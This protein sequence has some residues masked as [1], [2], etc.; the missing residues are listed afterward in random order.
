MKP[1][2]LLVAACAIAA[3][4]TDPTPGYSPYCIYPGD[5]LGVLKRSD[6]AKTVVIECIW[7]LADSEQCFTQ[8]VQTKPTA[9]TV[10]DQWT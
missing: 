8:R 3:C 4:V 6:A 5:T 9:C 1:L 7:L 10:G 2:L